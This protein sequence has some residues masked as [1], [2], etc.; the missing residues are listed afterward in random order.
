MKYELKNGKFLKDGHTMFEEDVLKDLERLVYLEAQGKQVNHLPME[1]YNAANKM[2]FGG[3]LE[4]VERGSGASKKTVTV[5]SSRLNG[6]DL[7]QWRKKYDKQRK[8]AKKWKK[9]AKFNKQLSMGLKQSKEFWEKS[10]KFNGKQVQFFEVIT[11][12]DRD[13]LHI[14]AQNIHLTKENEDLK[15][16]LDKIKEAHK[17]FLDTIEPEKTKGSTILGEEDD[18]YE[19]SVVSE[20]GPCLEFKVGVPFEVT[21]NTIHCDEILCHDFKVGETVIVHS[22]FCNSYSEDYVEMKSTT[23]NTISQ[24]YKGDLKKL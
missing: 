9:R 15:A 8:K 6:L 18:S 5:Q 24:V 11:V 16:E 13:R 10:S 12:D 23:R 4:W 1:V 2:T 20:R 21:G 17:E 14:K 7:W 22:E 19:F 3:F